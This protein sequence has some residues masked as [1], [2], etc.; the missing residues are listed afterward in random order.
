MFFEKKYGIRFFLYK[1]QSSQSR[2]EKRNLFLKSFFNSAIISTWS[3]KFAD[4]TLSR[5][6]FLTETNGKLLPASK[7]GFPL[8]EKFLQS[9]TDRNGKYSEYAHLKSY[10]IWLEKILV[11]SI[12]T[13]VEMILVFSVLF[14]EKAVKKYNQPMLT[15]DFVITKPTAQ[16]MKFSIKDFVS[17]CDKICSFLRIWSHLLKKSLLENCIFCVVAMRI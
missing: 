13:E 15:F 2:W 17:K 7:G 10:V 12:W 1:R 8:N 3:C 11:C 6:V 4:Y 5:I 14:S 16:K 9:V